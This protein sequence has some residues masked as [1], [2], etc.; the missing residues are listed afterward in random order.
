MAWEDV[1]ELC[2]TPSGDGLV[3]EHEPVARRA[4][5]RQPSST[6]D[7][8]VVDPQ[9]A[10]G[11]FYTQRGASADVHETE[12]LHGRQSD[13]INQDTNECGTEQCVDD[14]SK[15]IDN[16]EK[17]AETIEQRLTHLEEHLAYPRGKGS[18]HLDISESPPLL[19]LPPAI[20]ELRRLTWLEARNRDP[21]KTQFS[22]VEV[23]VGGACHPG[24]EDI[25]DGRDKPSKDYARVPGSRGYNTAPDR[26]RINSKPVLLILAGLL[27]QMQ[28]A[29]SMVILHPFKILVHHENEIKSILRGLEEKWSAVDDEK[30]ATHASVN[31]KSNSEP[32][33]S[34]M[35]DA[36]IAPT[37]FVKVFE[38]AG[39]GDSMRPEAV[40]QSNDRDQ[41]DE[42]I[43]GPSIVK[44]GE[45]K[46][47]DQV[48]RLKT[49][50]HHQATGVTDSL[51]ALRDLRC[52]V[53]FMDEDVKP[54]VDRFRDDTCQKVRFEDL[55][56]LFKPGDDVVTPLEGERDPIF[57]QSSETDRP[58][59]SPT[60]A[61]G[62]IRERY[63][64]VWRVVQVGCERTKLCFCT[65][66]ER[67][68]LAPR[69]S[70]PFLLQCYYVDSDG[71]QY[72]PVIENFEIHP[73]QGEK[74]ITMLDVFPLR[75]LKNACEVKDQL[76][77]RGEI[78]CDMASTSQQRHFKGKAVAIRQGHIVIEES[79]P[80]YLEG[81]VVVDFIEVLRR[82]PNWTPPFADQCRCDEERYPIRRWR[83]HNTD[84][85]ELLE[86]D[87]VQAENIID[88]QRKETLLLEEPILSL[89]WQ[90][91]HGRRLPDTFL[92]LL[93]ARVFA[94]FLPHHSFGKWLKL[95]IS[96]MCV[97]LK[98]W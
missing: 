68:E 95:S 12:S 40:L 33:T 1:Q 27:K 82:S 81:P 11:S 43:L 51:E 53:Q 70:K 61:D 69:T 65:G 97:L 49:V 13:H 16:T 75:F 30:L 45:T 24:V 54:L 59:G 22:A 85:Q 64:S 80:I 74:D 35:P 42:H 36:T 93:P 38:N 78:F 46:G 72:G 14:W 41:H 57:S 9:P 18:R 86:W 66:D 39:P 44:I 34:R 76:K 73:F 37:Q 31:F 7:Y 50:P 91:S 48:A 6:S 60:G 62:L 79:K 8:I 29:N 77:R 71:D 67:R 2:R 56:Y 21:S 87:A 52:L 17:S 23:V 84:G 88:V 58:T 28:S 92:I 32:S 5:A 94:F 47:I 55:W 3:C 20:P 26:I 25:I 89:G 10:S 83:P 4:T 63:Q 15:P 98:S 90:F 96:I 19:N